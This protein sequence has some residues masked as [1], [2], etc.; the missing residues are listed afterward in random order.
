MTQE[1]IEGIYTKIMDC[2]NEA[3]RL[4]ALALAFTLPLTPPMQIAIRQYADV[5]TRLEVLLGI[6]DLLT[7]DEQA[8]AE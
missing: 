3:S 7:N 5:V 8:V 4:S 2:R 1:T 6:Y